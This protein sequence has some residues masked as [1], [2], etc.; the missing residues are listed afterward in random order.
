MRIVD[1]C[2]RCCLLSLPSQSPLCFKPVFKPVPVH[3]FPVRG[4]TKNS[5]LTAAA[6]YGVLSFVLI[7]GF[8]FL[9]LCVCIHTY[10]CIWMCTRRWRESETTCATQF[11]TTICV[12]G[13]QLWQ[14]APLCTEPYKELKTTAPWPSTHSLVCVRAWLLSPAMP[15]SKKASYS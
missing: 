8:F 3:G 12:P 13:I 2:Q 1:D 15:N 7:L 6:V 5:W 4:L 10:A 14:Q 9:T 11:S